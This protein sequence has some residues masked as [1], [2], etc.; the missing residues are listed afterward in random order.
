MR[1]PFV[2]GHG[3]RNDFVV[4]PDPDGTTHGDLDPALVRQVCDRRSGIGADGVLRVLRGDVDGGADWFMDYRN[5]DG[6]V[7]QTCGNGIRVFA[8]YLADAGL[9]DPARPLAV[10]TRDGIKSVEF[11]D[12]GEVSVDMGRPQVGL[13]VKV[14]V[15]GLVLDAI[16]V[17]MGNP[18]AVVFVESLADAGALQA[19]PGYD[20]A[21]FPDGVNVEFV[22]RRGTRALAFRV[23]ERGVGETQSCGT[24]ACAVV[25]AAEHRSGE[26][27]TTYRVDV[28]GG[29]LTVTRGEDDHLHLKGPA[30]IVADGVWTG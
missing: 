16:S 6:T 17:D 30:V 8:R 13:P 11:C 3:T 15:D 2:K 26:P 23:F 14:A 21:D 12:D 7:S 20:T 1:F 9:I 22:V 19:A 29:T 27:G 4:L 5:A 25:A 28:P 18:H 24:G 10:D